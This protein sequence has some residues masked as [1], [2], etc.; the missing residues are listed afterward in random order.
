[1]KELLDLNAAV[2]EE[3]SRRIQDLTEENIKCR[4][5]WSM[6]TCSETR[7]ADASGESRRERRR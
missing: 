7:F 3:L 6:I 1:M 2:Q 4:G 5:F